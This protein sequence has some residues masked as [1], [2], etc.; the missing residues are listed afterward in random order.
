MNWTFDINSK[1]VKE[2]K[3]TIPNAL[4]DYTQ[5]ICLKCNQKFIY[6]RSDDVERFFRQFQSLKKGNLDLCFN[7]D[8]LDEKLLECKSLSTKK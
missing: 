2:A 7:C 3:I 6:E 8:E 5:K 4:I 1:L